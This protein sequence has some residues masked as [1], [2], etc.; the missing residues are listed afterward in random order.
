MGNYIEKI[1][2]SISRAEKKI[3]EIRKQDSLVFSIFTDLHTVDA[4]HEYMDRLIYALKL[5]TDKIEYDAVI[6]LGDNFAM[7]GRD[8]HISNE[9]LRARFKRI[10]SAIYSA[11]NH[12]IINVN[13]NHDAIG[14]DFFKADF[15]NDIVKGK[16]GNTSAVYGDSGS[17]YYVDYEK[18]NTR[19]V[20]LSLPYDSDIES[21]MPTP[22]WKFGKCQL[23]WLKNSALS[24]TKDV[25]I[26]SHVPFYYRYTGNK[27][28]TLPVW[29]GKNS[30]KSYIAAL[31]GEIGDLDEAISI[32]NEYYNR[33]NTRL[34]AC[35]SG[36]THED[37]L[38][39]PGEQKD[40]YKNPLPCCQI[41]T[42]ST[43]LFNGND[44]EIGL[45]LDI[46]VWNPSEGKLYMIRVGDGE[47]RDISV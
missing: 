12:P 13:G 4:E 25:I 32:V 6:D 45:S 23:D 35:L 34:V 10:F 44:R 2:D 3:S 27:E 30:K 15:W 24:T 11:T 7:L 47:D 22:L 28:E 33:D 29:D 21:E 17:Y 31:C 41:V 9:E 37:S 18:A 16:Y 19:L 26:L 8:L 40:E 5:I 39:L 36:H 46:A 20:I 14:T 38:R 42:E 43:V 1:G